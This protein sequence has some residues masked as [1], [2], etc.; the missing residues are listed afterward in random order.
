MTADQIAVASVLGTVLLLV[1]SLNLLLALLLWGAGRRGRGGCTGPGLVVRG[2]PWR[3]THKVK[4]CRDVT[5]LLEDSRRA[6][7]SQ[8]ARWA[9]P[10]PGGAPTAAGGSLAGQHVGGST[11]RSSVNLWD[12]S[13]HVGVTEPLH[14]SMWGAS[15]LKALDQGD[16]HNHSNS[17]SHNHSHNHSHSHSHNHNHSHSHD[18]NHSNNHSHSHS[19]SGQTDTLHTDNSESF[20]LSPGP[21]SSGPYPA[22]EVLSIMSGESKAKMSVWRPGYTV[23]TVT[24]SSLR[25]PGSDHGPFTDGSGQQ[26]TTERF[27]PADQVKRDKSPPRTPTAKDMIGEGYNMAQPYFESLEREGQTRPSRATNELQGDGQNGENS[28]GRRRYRTHKQSRMLWNSRRRETRHPGVNSTVSGHR[29]NG[30]D[31]FHVLETFREK[32]EHSSRSRTSVGLHQTLGSIQEEDTL[33]GISEHTVDP[34]EP[35]ME[36]VSRSSQADGSDRRESVDQIRPRPPYLD[37]SITDDAKFVLVGRHG[38]P[39]LGTDAAMLPQAQTTLSAEVMTATSPGRL[40]L[41][42]E[43]TTIPSGD[44]DTLAQKATGVTQS[45]Q[46]TRAGHEDQK[47][48]LPQRFRVNPQVSR[49]FTP[50]PIPSSRF[51]LSEEDLRI[52]HAESSSSPT[53]DELVSR[54]AGRPGRVRIGEVREATVRSQNSSEFPLPRDSLSSFTLSD[55]Q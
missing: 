53:I 49:P 50:Y 1:I 31:G 24:G 36:C 47:D 7:A 38:E 25:H 22:G 43:H 32:L 35:D 33:R 18:N 23:Y 5:R 9:R 17:H 8:V 48:A 45:A 4:D 26:Q 52:Y 14:G 34:T 28:E 40:P 21:W 46:A 29:E 11:T 15:E 39:T 30:P 13:R 6:G 27:M 12:S 16:L 37:L 55:V 42:T 41:Q 44:I 10:L 20:H 51:V 19:G 2:R 54:D 3:T